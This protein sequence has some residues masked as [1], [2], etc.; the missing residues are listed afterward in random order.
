MQNTVDYADLHIYIG[1]IMAI[2][3]RDPDLEERLERLAKMQSVPVSKHAMLR[4]IVGEATK[5]LRK[6]NGWRRSD[7]P[8][9]SPAAGAA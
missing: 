7:E 1:V 6:P 8:Q 9:E 3:F 2:S 4:A 5:D